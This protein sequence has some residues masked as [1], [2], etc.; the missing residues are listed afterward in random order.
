LRLGTGREIPTARGTEHGPHNP[1]GTPMR[2]S[3]ISFLLLA[4]SFPALAHHHRDDHESRRAW[5][6]HR[7]RVEDCGPRYVR[8]RP[9]PPP[10]SRRPRVVV[11]EGHR[12]CEQERVVVLAPPPPPMI[13]SAPLRL[14]IEF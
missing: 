11:H 10:W 9:L 12:W 3:T 14:W 2:L 1:K 5:K 13:V 6:H 4:M 7:A 8:E